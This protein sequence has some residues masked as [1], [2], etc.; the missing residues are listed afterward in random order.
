METKTSSK[1]LATLLV[2]LFVAGASAGCHSTY[3]DYCEQKQQCEGGND[4]DIDACIEE[5]RAQEDIASAYD[6]TDAYDK[7]A[8]CFKVKGSCKSGRFDT[9]SSCSAEATAYAT[10]NNAASG[11]KKN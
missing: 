10:C 8:D 3:K 4:K 6:C 1:V 7:Y 11:R 5:W 9:T 2:G